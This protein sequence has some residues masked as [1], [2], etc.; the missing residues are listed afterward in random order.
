[1]LYKTKKLKLLILWAVSTIDKKGSGSR[2]PSWVS[3]FLLKPKFIT[4]FGNRSASPPLK[5][6]C[7]LKIPFSKPTFFIFLKFVTVPGI[8][9]YIKR[10]KVQFK[11]NLLNFALFQI[12]NKYPPFNIIFEIKKK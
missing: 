4:K 3:I 12:K 11:E 6:C 10:Q 7:L 2:H 1:M 9:R 5:E 8:H